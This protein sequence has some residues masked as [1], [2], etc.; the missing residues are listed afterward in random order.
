ME[1]TAERLRELHKLQEV[2]IP[3]TFESPERIERKGINN[4]QLPHVVA[5]LKPH[6]VKKLLG[7]RTLWRT[8]TA[9]MKE[10]RDQR[11]YTEPRMCVCGNPTMVTHYKATLL[12]PAITY[13]GRECKE[14]AKKR[15]SK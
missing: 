4:L 10:K 9:Q 1:I 3:Q 15:R 14:C 5:I 8:T 7:E 13:Y 2:Y 12:S 11:R 6:K